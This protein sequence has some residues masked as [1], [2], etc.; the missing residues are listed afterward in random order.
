VT[1]TGSR[2]IT[3]RVRVDAPPGMRLKLLA[4]TVLVGA[5]LVAGLLV[6][7]RTRPDLA[8]EYAD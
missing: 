5:A 1:T 7:R 2:A 4:T 6:E 8:D 3:K